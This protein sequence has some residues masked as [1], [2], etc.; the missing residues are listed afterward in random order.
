ME[1]QIRKCK[2][3]GNETAVNIG[4]HN[5]KN[6]FRKPTFEDYIMLFIILMA[7]ISS[8][9]YN[10]DVNNIVE[11]YEGGDYCSNQIQLNNLETNSPP[12]LYQVNLSDLDSLNESN[13]K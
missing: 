11:Y 5:W 9:A 7:I 12:L 2:Y 8:Y 4:V 6:L 1:K 13:G 10:A 3:C